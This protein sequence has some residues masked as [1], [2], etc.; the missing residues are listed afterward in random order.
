MISLI[1]HSTAHLV[2]AVIG[3]TKVYQILELTSLIVASIAMI[4]LTSETF[5]IYAFKKTKKDLEK[6]IM[7]RTKELENLNTELMK[8]IKE[9]KNIEEKLQNHIEELEKWQKL[10]V[11]REQKMM[12][13]KETI[14]DLER[15]SE[16]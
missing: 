7:D 6:R 11:G 16:E 13:L 8:E 15:K 14:K 10:T 5:T 4:T 12:E 9:R 1:V 3:L 2:E